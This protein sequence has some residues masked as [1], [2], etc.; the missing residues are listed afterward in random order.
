MRTMQGD[1]ALAAALSTVANNYRGVGAYGE[2][3]QWITHNAEYAP[4]SGIR[5]YG[6]GARRKCPSWLMA[7]AGRLAAGTQEITP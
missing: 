2:R 5:N 6:D 4:C 3:I 1:D 7:P